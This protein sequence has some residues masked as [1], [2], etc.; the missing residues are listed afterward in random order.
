MLVITTSRYEVWNLVLV[1]LFLLNFGGTGS[2]VAVPVLS[3]TRGGGAYSF[4][5]CQLPRNGFSFVEA[6]ALGYPGSVPGH[7]GFVSLEYGISWTSIEPMSPASVGRL[8]SI[9]TPLEEVTSFLK[10]SYR[11]SIASCS[12]C[13]HNHRFP[14]HVFWGNKLLLPLGAFMLF[15]IHNVVSYN[16]L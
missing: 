15:L 8:L 6:W 9:G 16:Q 13:W 1:I 5:L 3:I 14:L 4:L 2:Y 7:T 12:F 11:F 10:C